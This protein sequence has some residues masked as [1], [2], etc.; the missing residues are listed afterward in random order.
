[1][2][3]QGM[4]RKGRKHLPKAGTRPDEDYVLKRSREDVVNFGRHRE[5]GSVGRYVMVA[6]AVLAVVCLLAFFAFS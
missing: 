1:M 2:G 3:S 5:M 4:K 6:V